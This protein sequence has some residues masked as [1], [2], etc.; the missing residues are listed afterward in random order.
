MSH[1]QNVRTLV[2]L[3]E[4]NDQLAMV[5]L[6]QDADPEVLADDI[7]YIIITLMASH[8]PVEKKRLRDKFMS[9]ITSWEVEQME[10]EYDETGHYGDS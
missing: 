3:A 2:E 6:I 10:L 5:R 4:T 7:A 8:S 1:Y 9:E